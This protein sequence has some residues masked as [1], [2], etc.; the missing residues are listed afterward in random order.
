MTVASAPVSNSQT[1]LLTRVVE[2]DTEVP[3]GY[4][5]GFNVRR[6][7]SSWRRIVSGNESA[8]VHVVPQQAKGSPDPSRTDL[9]S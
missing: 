9:R 3:W 5:W 2:R 7:E 1:T 8:E 4:A 6:T